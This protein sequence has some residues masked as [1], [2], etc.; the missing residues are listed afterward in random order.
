MRTSCRWLGLG[1]AAVACLVLAGPLGAVAPEIRDDAQMFSAAARKKADERVREIYRKHGRDVLIETFTSVPA[2]DMDKVKKM[3]KEARA[4]YFL[5]WAKERAGKR[6]VNGVYILICKEP[7]YLL[8]GVDEKEPHHFPKGIAAEIEGVFRK[9]FR[10]NRF[11]DGLD[12]ALTF[13]E[14]KLAKAK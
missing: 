8:A 9:E 13:I 6:V 12:K 3:D 14:E 7:Q 10:E 5:G 1:T 4:A 2:D 11:D